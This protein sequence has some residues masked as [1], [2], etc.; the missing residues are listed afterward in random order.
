MS[1][2]KHMSPNYRFVPSEA[3]SDIENRRHPNLKSLAKG[4]PCWK[5]IGLHLLVAASTFLP[6]G[7]QTRQSR[8]ANDSSAYQ[9]DSMAR[10]RTASESYM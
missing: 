6:S 4:I 2:Q 3:S 5:G 10:A 1:V 9:D 8:S 7:P